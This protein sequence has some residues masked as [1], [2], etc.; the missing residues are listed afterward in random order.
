MAVKVRDVY[1][2][3]HSSEGDEKELLEALL[4]KEA[5]HPHL[6]STFDWGVRPMGVSRAV[7][8]ACGE[9]GESLGAAAALLWPSCF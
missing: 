6:V 1:L 7:Q 2:D 9:L 5:A 4:G 8:R 3:P